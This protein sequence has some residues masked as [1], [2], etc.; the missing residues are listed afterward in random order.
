MFAFIF[1]AISLKYINTNKVF[2]R[3]DKLV[4]A[5]NDLIEN[6]KQDANPA[7]SFATVK[8]NGNSATT[9]TDPCDDAFSADMTNKCECDKWGTDYPDYGKETYVKLVQMLNN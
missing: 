6:E 1:V 8:S 7:T 5:N 4:S 2:A 3:K 9:Q